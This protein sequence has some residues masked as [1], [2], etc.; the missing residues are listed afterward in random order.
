MIDAGAD[1]VMATALTGEGPL[2]SAE[3]TTSI[4]STIATRARGRAGFVPAVIT[5]RTRTA[6]ELV[7]AAAE[8]GADAVM[9]TPI[10]PE[11]YAGRSESD[12]RGF[13][14]EVAGAVSIPLVLFNYPSLTG[15]DF[16]PSFVSSLS[17][18]D[19]IGYI[20]ESTGDSRRV[21]AI[22]RLCGD[23]ITVICGNPNA[24]FESIALGCSAWITGIMN[25][26]PRSARR[27]MQLILDGRDL[28]AA[29]AVYYRHL[30]PLVDLM[31]RNSNPTGTIKAAMR[32]RGLPAGV[33][34]RPGS[35]VSAGDIAALREWARVVDADE[36]AARILP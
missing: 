7:R 5:Y 24:A 31:T 30:L 16:T 12:V 36:R 8:L 13:Y 23:R 35:D 34:R 15:V 28:A 21:H 17:S 3:E 11:L 2:L 32:V 1:F 10:V 18:I 25:A 26:A 6:I 14:E 20:K 33:P 4:W 9:V 19:A 22:H 27:M 29:R